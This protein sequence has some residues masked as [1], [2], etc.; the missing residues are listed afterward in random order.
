MLKNILDF[1]DSFS[2]ESTCS[3]NVCIC[4]KSL[5]YVNEHFG[6]RVNWRH[7]WRSSELKPVTAAVLSCHSLY[8]HYKS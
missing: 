2:E 4:S 5:S 6:D 1:L 3:E 7:R 8:C